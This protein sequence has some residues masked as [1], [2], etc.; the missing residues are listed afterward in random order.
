MDMKFHLLAISLLIS[1]IVSAQEKTTI[2]VIVPHPDDDVY[3]VGNQRDLG[4]WNPSKIKMY[5]V[6]DYLRMISIPFYFPAEFMFTRGSYESEGIIYDLDNNPNIYL[7]EYIKEKVFKIKGWKDELLK[8]KFTTNYKF[9]PFEAKVFNEERKLKVYL[10]KSYSLEKRY[11]VIFIHDTGNHFKIVTKLLDLWSEQDYKSF[12]DCIVIG[13]PY[14]T[15]EELLFDPN[16][17]DSDV[18]RDYIIYDAASFVRSKYSTSGFNILVGQGITADFNQ[19]VITSKN[20]PF[21]ALINL[22]PIYSNEK[23]L[24]VMSYLKNRNDEALYYFL[25]KSQ[26]QKTSNNTDFNRKYDLNNDISFTEKFYKTTP[27][28]LFLDVFQDAL[29]YIFKDYRNLENYQNFSD[30]IYRYENNVMN[31]YNMEVEYHENDIEYFMQD[32]LQRK[33][34]QMYSELLN[35]IEL[36]NI[37]GIDD[38]RYKLSSIDQAKHYYLM[39]LFEESKQRW[40][41]ILNEYNP[42][43][44]DYELAQ[45]YFDNIEYAL[46]SI[47]K[48]GKPKE[49]FDFLDKFKLKF[50]LYILESYYLMAKYSSKYK[51]VSMRGE[52]ALQFCKENYRENQLFK[53]S[54][55]DNINFN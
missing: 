8:A 22:N 37:N 26:Y 43:E 44:N 41:D 32:I 17:Q 42:D 28:N 16:T 39:D 5:K 15:E 31:T 48:S 2:K 36:K 19:K 24:K 47:V 38:K 25:A 13:V 1:T 4:D 40:N 18:L 34:A 7:E 3:I 46:M 45:M 55:L 53:Y 49:V 10:P 29:K 6:S 54:D 14:T 52:T 21:D 9:E 33:D 11:P 51:L 12:P 50:P 20:N 23:D 27:E 30:F 35:F